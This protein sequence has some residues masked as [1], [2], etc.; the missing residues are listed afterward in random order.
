MMGLGKPKL[1]TKFEV[2]A[3]ILK[4]KP[5]ILGNSSNPGPYALLLIVGYD[6]GPWQ[7]PATCQM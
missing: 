2:V 3:E 5:Q 6:E 4:G 1:L 7:T